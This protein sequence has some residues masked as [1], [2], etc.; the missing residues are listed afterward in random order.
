MTSRDRALTALNHREPDRIP[1]DLGSSIVTSITRNAYVDLK[2]FLGMPLEEIKML[3]HVQ[4]LPYVDEELLKR[5]EVDFRIVQLPPLTAPAL[6]SMDEGEYWAFVDRWGAKLHMPKKNGYYYDWVEFP[7]KEASL[8]ALEKFQWPAPDPPEYLEELRRQAEYL[9]YQTDYTLVGT[10]IIGGGV[11]EQ[12]ARTIGMENFLIAL[13][14]DPLFA[15]RFME[16]LTDLYIECT[17]RYLDQVGPFLHVF[18]YWDDLAGQN[19]LLISREHY[20]QQI[21]PKQRRL[22]EAIRKKTR[23]KLFYHGCGAMYN[24]I[25]DLIEVG[26][27]ILN[28]VQVS[29]EGM[30]PLRLKREFGKDVVF[31]GGGVDTQQTFP[32]GTAAEVEDEVRRRIDELAPGGGFVFSTVHNIQPLVPAAN[33]VAAFETVLRYGHYKHSGA[34]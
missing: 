32:F 1:I 6:H 20:R 10:G 25:P 15:D 16:Q 23:A 17:D 13:K 19:S 14:V 24:L 26:F 18:T 9:Y 3:D 7:M 21:K 28:P 29:A 30:D 34:I 33:V 22:V 4:Q 31:W 8:A 27:D 2:K 5:F 11:F 12:P